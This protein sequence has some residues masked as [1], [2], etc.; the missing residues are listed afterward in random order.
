MPRTGLTPE[1]LKQKALDAAELVI[2]KS[3]F[4]R[5]KL[6]DVARDLGVSHAA[7][8]KHF[9]SKEELL[10]AVTQ[11]WLE[12]ID[13]AL[14]EVCQRRESVKAR[15]Q[16]WFTTLHRLKREKVMAD[17]ELYQAFNTSSV[18]EMPSISCH[19]ATMRAQLEALVSE[20]I[21]LGELA[22]GDSSR[23]AA[24]LFDGTMAFHHPRLV[25]DYLGADR[26]HELSELL[27]LL[28]KGLSA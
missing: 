21:D 15:L 8:Y 26:S 6:T 10:D 3:G 4:D 2:R 18:R 27:Q 25:L 14:A 13:A 1:E 9:A 7:L 16:A 11:R 20:G 23:I 5:S 17:P 22:P 24:L 12:R 28:L 19:M